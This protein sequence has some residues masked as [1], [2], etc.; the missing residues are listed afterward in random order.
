LF[1]ATG[2]VKKSEYEALQAQMKD[3]LGEIEEANAQIDALTEELAETSSDLTAT[4]QKL[5][6]TEQRLAAVEEANDQLQQE[7][8]DLLKD[9]TKLD[10]SAAKL[11]VALKELAER[12][13]AADRR[14]AEFKQ[15]LAKFQKLIDAGKL[16]VEI[17]EGRMVLVLPTDILFSSGSARLSDEGDAAIREVAAV[18]ATMVDRRFQVEGHTDN[19]PIKNKQFRNNWELASGRALNVVASLTDAGV[20]GEVLSAAS[21]G[22]YRPVAK[23]D[24]SENRAKNRRI[25]IVL[26]PDL[27]ELPGFAELKKTVAGQ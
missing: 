13:A 15:L 25:E 27:S 12:K 9:K 11:K 26:V 8:A 22:E 4:S 3:R 17:V 14:V 21:Y 6:R 1:A 24:N 10:E 16:K 19:V 18:L 7:L 23:N 2:C 5:A 20:L